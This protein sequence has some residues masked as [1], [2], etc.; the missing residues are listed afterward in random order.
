[1][2]K[3]NQSTGIIYSVKNI[4]TGEYYIGATTNSLKSRKEDHEAKANKNQGYYF[5]DAIATYGKESF[6]WN[7]I[8]T[9]S[10]IEELAIKEKEHIVKFDSK[11]NG[12]NSDEGGGFKKKVYQYNLVTGSLVEVYGCLSSAASAINATK[13]DISRACLSVNKT[14]AGYY[15]S[16]KHIEPFKPPHDKRKKVVSMFTLEEVLLDE[17][18]SVAEASR[19]TGISKSSIAKVC[20]GEREQCGGFKWKYY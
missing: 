10:T 8:D 13:Q 9:A 19:L 16:Y 5:H 17:F 18:N 7:Q 20:R 3:N 2:K 1:M 11:E 12:Y 14:Y 4:V 6:E 15:W